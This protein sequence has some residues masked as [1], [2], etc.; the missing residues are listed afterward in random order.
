MYNLPNGQTWDHASVAFYGILP[1]DQL[2]TNE[3]FGNFVIKYGFYPTRDELM[4]YLYNRRIIH[5][6]KKSMPFCLG[7]FVDAVL[8]ENADIMRNITP[9]EFARRFGASRPISSRKELE[10]HKI[11]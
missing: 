9:A 4:V 1:R 11:G 7:P 8:E 6:D 2:S 5:G 3:G 10:H